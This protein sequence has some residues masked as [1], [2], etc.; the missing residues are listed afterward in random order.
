M[1]NVSRKKESYERPR[2][3][4]ILLEAKNAVL[5]SCTG[6]EPSNSCSNGDTNE[7][8]GCVS[9]YDAPVCPS[10]CTLHSCIL[11]DCVQ[12]DPDTGCVGCDQA[13]DMNV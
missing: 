12:Y 7:E 9:G 13:A 1:K 8:P 10:V 3:E 11:V 5:T 4:I 2:M 6:N